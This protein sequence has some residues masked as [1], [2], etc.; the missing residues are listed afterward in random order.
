VV[1]LDD[2]PVNDKI[3]LQ[4]AGLQAQVLWGEADAAK[5]SRYDDVC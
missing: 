5:T 4:L 2:F 1:K 3:A